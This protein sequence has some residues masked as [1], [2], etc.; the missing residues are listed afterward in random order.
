MGHWLL[1]PKPARIDEIKEFLLIR[2][3]YYRYD[4]EIEEINEIKW[5]INLPAWV[6]LP[7]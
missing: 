1:L 4:P 5:K 6:N 2:L 7:F 3:D